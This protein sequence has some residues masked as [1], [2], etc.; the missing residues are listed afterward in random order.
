M[1][2]AT[3]ST[4]LPLSWRKIRSRAFSLL[5]IVW[6][7]GRTTGEK[8]RR[9]GA[10]LHHPN[11]GFPGPQ[12]QNDGVLAHNPL[13]VALGL[14]QVDVQPPHHHRRYQQGTQAQE[15]I[16]THTVVSLCRIT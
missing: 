6:P 8:D 9:P 16:D 1:W 15:F 12:R 13:L 3:S 14:P 10:T 2:S 5:G 7:L 4:P 11:D